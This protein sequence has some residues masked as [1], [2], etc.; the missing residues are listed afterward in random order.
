MKTNA[1]KFY[2]RELTETVAP[3]P[4]FINAISEFFDT[5]PSD[6][7]VELGYYARESEIS[8]STV[9]PEAGISID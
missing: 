4:E 5:D 3:S 9:A 7:L 6:L 2:G 8:T 1:T